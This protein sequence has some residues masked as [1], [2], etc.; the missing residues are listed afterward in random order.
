MSDLNIAVLPGDGIGEEVMNAAGKVL[1]AIEPKIG[2]CFNL[3]YQKAGAQHYLDTGVALPDSVLKVC[4]ESD[5]IL[6]G[7]MGLPHVRSK[8]GTE[9]IPQLDLRFHFDLYAGVRPIRTFKGLPSPLS[10]PKAAEIDM[11]LVRENTEGLFYARGRPDVRVVD[12]EETEI[13]DTMKISRKGTERICKY[14]F[15]IAERRAKMKGRAGRVT[16]I[17]KAN[18]FT[19]MA[20]WRR[21]FEETAQ[22]FPSVAADS[23]Y[24]DAMALN[25]LMKPWNYDVMVTE[26]MYGDI[27]SDL[28]AGLVGGMGMAPSADIGD[29]HGLFQPAHGTAPDIMGKGKAN[30]SAMILSAAMMLDW[31]AG[32]HGDER[33]SKGATMIE[34]AIE[35]VFAAGN[36][37]P[38]E[39]GGSHGSEEVTS[40]IIKEINQG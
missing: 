37:R 31:L 36:I 23:A 20:F 15:Q 25:L 19:S 28:I 24:V 13:F 40:A 33:L 29:K 11:V 3:N 21:V 9:I 22:S 16:S 2:V 4:D 5:A 35:R 1:A 7:A 8:D 12:G 6:F 14:A 26:N 17:D 18:V 39:L 38:M 10:S 30:P 32:R 34:R 27:L